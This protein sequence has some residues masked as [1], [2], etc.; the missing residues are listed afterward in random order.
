MQARMNAQASETYE[1]SYAETL[2]PKEGLRPTRDY[3]Y[4]QE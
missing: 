3:T 4:Q 2:W 1:H